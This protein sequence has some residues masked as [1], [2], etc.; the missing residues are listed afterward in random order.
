MA[1]AGPNILSHWHP[2]EQSS[3][4]QPR[5]TGA[6]VV[7]VWSTLFYYREDRETLKTYFTVK[8]K[9]EGAMDM[10]WQE[11]NMV[12]KVTGTST[13]TSLVQHGATEETQT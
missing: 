13:S 8:E 6:N 2:P 12:S 7:R 11:K 5:R 4:H 1:S 3:N 9:Q 10:Y